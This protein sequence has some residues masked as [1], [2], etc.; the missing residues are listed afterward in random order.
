MRNTLHVD[1]IRLVRAGSSRRGLSEPNTGPNP[2]TG[3]HSSNLYHG[4]KAA[5]L[6]QGDTGAQLCQ[7][8][9][10]DTGR[11]VERLVAL[12]QTALGFLVALVELGELASGLDERGMV[13]SE[14]GSGGKRQA[15]HFSLRASRPR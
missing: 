13:G 4:S 11:P 14:E 9:Q 8:G 12:L 1:G 15:T 2:R 6:C 10:A 5:P 7:G 3:K